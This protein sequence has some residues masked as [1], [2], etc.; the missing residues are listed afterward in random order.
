MLMT[1]L[2]PAALLST[3]PAS[4]ALAAAPTAAGASAADDPAKPHATPAAGVLAAVNGDVKIDRPGTSAPIAGAIGVRLLPGDLV[5]VGAASSATVYLAG[6][7]IV[8]VPAGNRI[9][10]PKA[11]TAPKAT[12]AIAGLTPAMSSRSVE[13][14]EAGLWVLNDPQGS[15]LLTAMRGGGDDWTADPA[16]GPMP[17]S[18]RF[19][20]VLEPRPR[21]LWAADAPVRLVIGRGQDVVWRSPTTIAGPLTLPDNVSELRAGEVYRWWLESPDGGAPLSEAVPFRIADKK[22]QTDATRFEKE[23]AGLAGNDDAPALA[24]LM[25]C[26]YYVQVG[27]WT[28]VVSAASELHHR[29]PGSAAAARALD[30]SRQQMRLGEDAMAR[31]LTPGDGQA[32]PR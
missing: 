12:P 1:A 4:R 11:T 20:T 32:I 7:G 8:R 5:R 14:L 16:A 24:S 17:L 28:R 22:T 25:R 27:A 29:D 10:I 15:V 30:G 23:L 21:L 9:E 2:L 18:P 3:G 6:G 19:E 13:V 31:L 26:G